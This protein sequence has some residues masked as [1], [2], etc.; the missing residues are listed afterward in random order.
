MFVPEAA[1][2]RVLEAAAPTCAA[3]T[4]IR[5]DDFRGVLCLVQ[6]LDGALGVNPNPN[7]SPSPN[8]SPDPNPDLVQVLDGTLGVGQRLVSA[9][10]KKEYTVTGVELM[11]PLGS[12]PLPSLG[13]GMVGCAVLGMKA[14]QEACVGDTL[15]DPAAVQPPLQRVRRISQS[16]WSVLT[17][18]E[19]SVARMQAPRGLGPWHGRRCLELGSGSGAAGMALGKWG[20]SEVRVALGQHSGASLRLFMH[21]SS[22]SVVHGRWRSCVCIPDAACCLPSDVGPVPGCMR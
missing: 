1:A 12:T 16:A 5:Y 19:L 18:C 17:V 10:T 14:I 11:R 20:A 4:C 3:P 2:P 9:A 21:A 13:P 7:P 22:A 6:V 8:P 15:C